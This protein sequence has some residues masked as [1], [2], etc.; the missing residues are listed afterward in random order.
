MIDCNLLRRLKS[1]SEPPGILVMVSSDHLMKSIVKLL[2]TSFMI[3]KAKTDEEAWQQLQDSSM[4]ALIICDL[5]LS[6]TELAILGRIRQSANAR[7]AATPILVL[8]SEQNTDEDRDAAIRS[9]ATDFI[10][11]PFTSSELLTRAKLHAQIMNVNA[12]AGASLSVQTPALRAMNH[13]L[14]ENAFISRLNQ[15]ISFSQRHRSFISV[16]KIRIDGL[17]Q[18]LKQQGK[19]AVVEVI[20]AASTSIQ[21]IARAEDI[22]SYI[23]KGQFLVLYPATNGIGA[24]IALKRISQSLRTVKV[25][26]KQ[27]EL[28]LTMS[29][30]MVSSPGDDK[31][32]D[33]V[34]LKAVEKRMNEAIANGGNCVISQN[35]S[36]QKSELSV[37]S[38]LRMIENDQI[39]NL[40]P[41]LRTTTLRVLPLIE[42][43]DEVLSLS[44][45]DLVSHLKKQ[46]SRRR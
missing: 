30:G 18:I 32:N 41:Y 4:P 26:E 39:D 23:G 10:N 29:T 13:L 14:S 34:I 21:N 35:L 27:P 8:V 16:A 1:L 19:P 15:E 44:S 40:K 45:D 9:G 36:G 11:V 2:D 38:A 3:K 24:S 46:L 31:I 33:E 17:S 37:D 25:S 7:L 22:V 6:S 12:D 20:K 43:A 5:E 42:S 28:S